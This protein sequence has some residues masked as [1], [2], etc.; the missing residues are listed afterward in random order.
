[1][2]WA[3]PPGGP[4]TQVSQAASHLWRT[5]AESQQEGGLESKAG[6]GREE[7]SPPPRASSGPRTT[8]H[9]RLSVRDLHRDLEERVLSRPAPQAVPNLRDSGF[10]PFFHYSIKQYINSLKRILKI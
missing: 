10:V 3:P 8:Q 9:L 5:G 1:M 6:T 7:G 2:T 4:G